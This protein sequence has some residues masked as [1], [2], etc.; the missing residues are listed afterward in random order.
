MAEF[1]NKNIKYLRQKK[2]ISQQD[3]ADKVGI[4]RS[5]I[6]RIE[7]SE[8]ETT[9]PTAEKIAQT[10]NVSFADLVSKDLTLSNENLTEN[11]IESLNLL[12]QY[13]IL[14]DKD[15]ALT[16]EQKK[17]FIDFLTEK[18][19]EVDKKMNIE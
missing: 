6:S 9:V 1:L 3:L 2:N 10:L 12:E 11:N 5:T 15:S 17:F 7:N 8:I 16:E 18:H 4:D 13:H 19:K 14:F